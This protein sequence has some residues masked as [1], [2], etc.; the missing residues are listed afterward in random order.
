MRRLAVLALVGCNMAPPP[1]APTSASDP[2]ANPTPPPPS[3]SAP[4]RA[5]QPSVEHPNPPPAP[6]PRTYGPA[7]RASAPNAIVAAPSQPMRALAVTPDGVA[8]VTADVSGNVR[9]WPALDGTYEPVVL[10]MRRPVALAVMRSRTDL[11]IAG[12]DGAGQLEVMQATALGSAVPSHWIEL[13]RPAIAVHAT[14]RGFLV[15]RDDQHL[16][17][18]LPDGQ[19]AG[20]LEPPPGTNIAAIAVQGEAMLALLSGGDAVHARRLA[21]TGKLEWGTETAALPIVPGAIALAPNHEAI[22]GVAQNARLP[23]LVVVGLEHGDILAEGPANALDPAAQPLGFLNATTVLVHFTGFTTLWHTDMP[24]DS[25]AELAEDRRF[26]V[27]AVAGPHAVFGTG[28][29]LMLADAA[30]TTSELGFRIATLGSI[31]PG[32]HSLLATDGTHV[33]RIGIDLRDHTSYELPQPHD[34]PVSVLALLDANHVLVDSYQTETYYDVI[35]LDT[36]EVTPLSMYERFAAYDPPTH[37]AAFITADSVLFRRFD[38]K[39]GAFGNAAELATSSAAS[40]LFDGSDAHVTV[41]HADETYSDLLVTRIR[42]EAGT[43]KLARTIRHKVAINAD[44]DDVLAP[45]PAFVRSVASRDGKL[46]A[47]L[48]GGRFSLRDAGGE[49]RWTVPSAGAND[50]TW[51]PSG[52]LFATGAGIARVSLEDGSFTERRC[53]WQFGL[54]ND[55]ID[56]FASAMMCDAE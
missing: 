39:T 37:L 3:P 4:A 6:A 28:A 22:A 36:L 26:S 19:L 7:P 42:P 35:A 40:V 5:S 8:A 51:L 12:I 52:E 34:N 56:N 55:P 24:D 11:A 10:H 9:L 1:P 15:E 14:P 13:P 54:W 49:T 44:G 21:F 46:V 27:A 29:S 23:R 18:V 17:F 41:Y 48:S 25:F 45:A 50:L 30:G 32:A 2:W 43:L 20:D 53:G 47:T 38:S 33:V 31:A 16:V